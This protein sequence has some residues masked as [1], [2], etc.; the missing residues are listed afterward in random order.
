MHGEEGKGEGGRG[1]SGCETDVVAPSSLLA[2]VHIPLFFNGTTVKV[3][4]MTRE[5]W[6]YKDRGRE[7]EMVGVCRGGERRNKR[8]RKRAID[9]RITEILSLPHTRPPL[10]LSFVYALFSS[11]T[12]IQMKQGRER[13]GKESTQV[14]ASLLYPT[15]FQSP[16][17]PRKR[18]YSLKAPTHS[19][20]TLT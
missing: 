6:R 12:F 15:C 5:R 4:R 16:L 10:S 19:V 3:R 18:S 1:V 11:H 14:T 7:M 9:E 2:F 20:L 17:T 13:E 8:Q